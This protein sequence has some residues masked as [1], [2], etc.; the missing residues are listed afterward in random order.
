MEKSWFYHSPNRKTPMFLKVRIT[1]AL[2]CNE[3]TVLQIMTYFIESPGHLFFL[4]LLQRKRASVPRPLLVRTFTVRF[5]MHL[6]PFP[7]GC[8]CY[9]GAGWAG[10]RATHRQRSDV[11]VSFM[12][13]SK[14]R[15]TLKKGGR[16]EMKQSHTIP[17]ITLTT[18]STGKWRFKSWLQTDEGEGWMMDKP[19]EV[20]IGWLEEYK[21]YFFLK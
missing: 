19:Y 9:E 5:I 8:C 3:E 2:G 1:T 7:G 10:S 18:H 12:E 17:L 16:P 15:H 13:Q 14:E 6:L 21:Y 20:K 11:T 4:C